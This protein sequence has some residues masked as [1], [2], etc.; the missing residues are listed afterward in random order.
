MP[1]LAPVNDLSDD[2]KLNDATAPGS[3]PKSLGGPLKRRG[4]RP[5]RGSFSF[6]ADR[7]HVGS[8][9]CDDP[10]HLANLIRRTCGCQSDCFTSF[11]HD[12]SLREWMQLRTMLR[13]MK[14]LEK[15]EY[16]R[17]LQFES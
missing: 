12:T 4:F 8:G 9:P 15:D 7:K 3:K 6:K 2:E 14:K 13:K 17:V 11:R 16:V 5:R 10:K 1:A